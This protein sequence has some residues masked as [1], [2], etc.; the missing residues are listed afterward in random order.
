MKSVFSRSTLAIFISSVAA[1]LALSVIAASREDGSV[2]G[3][4]SG[5]GVFSRSAVGYSLLYGA[6]RD[7]E[8]PVIAGTR[9][10]IRRAGN[11]GTLIVAEPSVE[12]I[13]SAG[14]GYQ[15]TEVK[16]LLFV[17]PKWK[18]LADAENPRWIS[19]MSPAP[20]QEA[21]TVLGMVSIGMGRVFRKEPPERWTVNEFPYSPEI[22]G[23][24]Q[25]M[26]PSERMRTIVGD[27]E[28]A[29]L[30]EMT[31]GEGE[32]AMLAE[33]MFGGR[34]VWILSDPDV[35]S[36]HGIHK[37][38][39]AEFAA[40][41]IKALSNAGSENFRGR[42]SI[43]FDETV[44]LF[45]AP[46][47][48]IMKMML[49]FPYVIITILTCISAALLAAAGARRFGAPA[50]SKPALDFGNAQLI[51][52]SARLLDY[53]GHHAVTLERYARM[54]FAEAARA[55]HAPELPGERERAEWAERVGRSRGVSVSYASILQGM[56]G[57]ISSLM[58]TARL[59]YKWKGEI[60]NGSSVRRKRR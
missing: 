42:R 11:R 50:A 2:R 17:L 6:L 46:A 53:G 19:K 59:A 38:Q 48:S 52:N 10:P 44:H 15:L 20:A 60:L 18:W 24:V 37:G 55:M 57:T 14:N 28:G 31:F 9:D 54:T 8:M 7:M 29:L 58:E 4:A 34:V 49:S 45:S 27:S 16:R 32:G 3:D 26:R 25:L 12:F 33:M 43:V 21:E 22:S 35:I 41:L 51:D 56:G 1:L 47:D 40:S 39:N 13:L 5:P 30:A 23:V 36:N